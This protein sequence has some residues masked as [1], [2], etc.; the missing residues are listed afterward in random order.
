MISQKSGHPIIKDNTVLV[1]DTLILNEAS[2]ETGNIEYSGSV[3]I[4]GDVKP[5][6]RVEASGDIHVDGT[7]ENADLISGNTVHVLKG[8]ICTNAMENQ[9]HQDDKLQ[10]KLSWVF[11]EFRN[12][13]KVG[14]RQFI[15]TKQ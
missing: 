15:K 9:E 14:R 6:V 2:L 8:V 11:Q 4:S 7:V 1:D 13:L 10:S 12:D 5:N 3:K